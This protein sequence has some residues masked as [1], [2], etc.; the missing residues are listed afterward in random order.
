MC[1]AASASC[2]FAASTSYRVAASSCQTIAA[3]SWKS[4]AASYLDVKSSLQAVDLPYQAVVASCQADAL[5]P[6]EAFDR[7]T[8]IVMGT[9]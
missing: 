4:V 1:R 8:S 9:N 6:N 5:S 7:A 3:S 2:R